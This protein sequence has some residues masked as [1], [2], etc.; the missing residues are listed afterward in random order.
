MKD[1][2]R[3][4][5]QGRIQEIAALVQKKI[6][7]QQTAHFTA[8]I[9]N[10][11]S[12]V[13]AED[14]IQYKNEDLQG[15]MATLHRHIKDSPSNESLIF[16]P[17]VEEHGWQSPH[18]VLILHHTDIRYLID[19]IRN[20]LSHHQ[21]RIHTLFH[22]YFA[23]E[24]DEQGNILSI[25]QQ[26]KGVSDKSHH[27]LLM[28]MEIDH[29]SQMSDIRELNKEINKTISDVQVVAQDYPQMVS[30][31][32]KVSESLNNTQHI[33]I[34]LVEECKAFLEWMKNGHFTFLAYDE[35]EVNDEG[36]QPVADSGVGL[37]RLHD[38]PK[39]KL[40]EEMSKNQVEAAG[41]NAP[42]LFAKSGR[43]STVHRSAYSDYIVIR[44]F[45]ANGNI[46]GGYRFMGLYKHNV[47]LNSA[48]D[49][50]LIRQKI[51]T[52]LD[53][54]NIPSD[55]YNYAELLHILGT[56]PRDELFQA[57]VDHLLKVGLNVLYIQERRK[58]KLFLRESMDNKFLSA[59]FYA[60]RDRLNS[61][62][63][64]Q[65]YDL[66]SQHLDIESSTTS[67]WFS[68]SSLARCRFVFKLK[69]PLDEQL[70]EAELEDKTI[71]LARD[72]NQ[73]LQTALNDV[74]GEENGVEIYQQYR[75][76]FPASYI[77][78]NNPRVA[79]ADIDRMRTLT[80]DQQQSLGLTFYRSISPESNELKIKIYRQ[81]S[82]LSLSDMIPVL[83][84]FGLKVIE[85]YPYA[86][87]QQ[88]EI[89]W[90]YNFNIEFP[91]DSNIETDQF[92][93]LLSD[94]FIAVWQNQ[95]EN[96]SFNQLILRAGLNW[97]QVSMLRAYSR[98][99]KQ[100]VF[101]FSQKFISTSLTNHTDIAK[102]LIAYFDCRFNPEKKRSERT[103]QRLT[104]QLNGLFEKVDSLSEDRI[105][106][107]FLELM[108]AT[109][110]TNYFQSGEASS[111]KDY[112]S[113]KMDPHQIKDIP[114]PRPRFEIF[115]YSPRVE[116]V[117]LRGGKVARGGL[118]WSDRTE[119]FR[120]EILGLVKAQQVK[121]AVIVPVGAKGGF[122][123][124]QLPSSSDRE[125][126][127]KEGVACYRLFIRGLLDLTD[128]IIEGQT[129]AP[130]NTVCYDES[131]TYLVVAADKGTA[132]FSDIANEISVEYGHWLGDA[133]AS[134]G[135]NGYDHKK[136][137]I[138]ARGAWVS[139]QR[140]FREMGINIQEQPFT[141]VGIGDMAGDVFGNG[142]LLS[143]QIKLVGA[144]NH[145]HIFIDPKPDPKTSFKE[146]Q[147]LFKLPRSSWEDYNQQLISKGGG[148]FKRSAKA[149]TLTPEI[150]HLVNTDKTS[151]TPTEL[152]S[153]LLKANVDMLWNGG[154][155]T[156]VKASNELH[157]DVGDKA[158]D[159][160]RVNANEI[161]C[162]VVGEGGNLGLT[163]LARIEYGLAGGSIFTDF[164]DNAG[165]VDCSDHEVNIKILL[166]KQ[167]AD[168]ELTSKQRNRHLESMTDSVAKLVLNNNYKQTQAIALA[169]METTRR[170][171]EYRRV[172]HYLESTGKLNRALEFLPDD[173][174]L[175]ERKVQDQGLT[176]PELSI[177]IS[178][179]K[180]DM[181]EALMHSDLGD[182]PFLMLSAE[183]AFPNTL[184][185]NFS[186]G[187]TNHPLRKEIIATQIANDMFNHMGV[188][189]VD[190]MHSSTGAS[191][192]DI[193]KAYV[194]AKE[195]FSLD[196]IWAAIEDLD[197]LVKSELQYHMMLRAS[198]LVRRASRWIIQNHR[199]HL[200]ISAIV[201]LYQQ[202]I[203]GLEKQLSALLPEPLFEQ[204]QQARNEFIDKGVP[205]KLAST[206][207]SCEYLYDFLGIIAIGNTL[208]KDI[209]IVA[210]GFF[211][212]AEKMDLDDFS[213]HLEKKM[214]TSTYWQVMARESL[215]DDLEWQQRQLTQNLLSH[216]DCD[217]ENMQTAV[218]AWLNKQELLINRWKQLVLEIHN[219]NDSDM[220]IF[221]IAIRELSNLSQAT[222]TQ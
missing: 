68:E 149:I 157:S 5:T 50:P 22:A 191:H 69:T 18:S 38:Q 150:Q 186:E 33:A 139:V 29:H 125:A 173:E 89:F 31:I 164:I 78:E 2:T 133:F 220:A 205:E 155:G 12:H 66:L 136:M 53:C 104:E 153:L 123:A 57:S 10:I 148:I 185:K 84:N 9:E 16:N 109:L 175:S 115:V 184:V 207:A 219:Y 187:V 25:A 210:T 127:L 24:R 48:T 162:K 94:A 79:V 35:Y 213:N 74:F 82:Q 40:F 216:N 45:D 92:Q 178:Y 55:T 30:L 132:T 169:H 14:L 91:F 81:G 144:F 70:N 52:I 114:L 161:N 126:F 217:V 198:R 177:L 128:N 195:I 1:N 85:E 6:P 61:H 39:T 204:W 44:R 60:P 37:F 3:S 196:K 20:T 103:A 80:G 13:A 202:S 124:K 65:V 88:T 209:N 49:I 63:T 34:E 163:Q 43:I 41:T 99:M 93:K 54:S 23:I 105:L 197:H 171:E 165:G 174:S 32:D 182:D 211:T 143:Q 97:R 141:V 189:F 110:R 166:D 172:I 222:L 199:T 212:L 119:D 122:I 154:I 15:L 152:I 83:E 113:L 112:L 101:G 167:I 168:G 142:M 96:D 28:Y 147:R 206:L 71:E 47:Y 129:T 59:I 67:T 221:S 77:D 117:H 73:D 181:K 7:A 72:W 138:T 160:L 11:F 106:R 95:A 51:Q 201:K 156:Y 193:A 134:G 107:H 111:H 176:Q 87:E 183:S 215:R 145:L 118:R 194:V 208:S 42:I 86:I 179:T 56:F 102:K 17:N 137:G 27:E 116:G 135:S 108:Q 218:D 26:D 158:N 58:V 130:A 146:R 98:Y 19:S 192:G 188:S 21:I 140:H 90:I 8:L 120:T 131:D 46:I 190:R 36:I 180:A 121:N 170:T 4:N 76:S 62:L 75:N 159:N 100:I 151:V 214:P 203:A 200:E 64:E